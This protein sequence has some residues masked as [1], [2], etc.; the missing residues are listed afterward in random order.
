MPANYDEPLHVDYKVVNRSADNVTK[1][2]QRRSRL[3]DPARTA[4]STDRV[5]ARVRSLRLDES[6]DTAQSHPRSPRSREGSGSGSGWATPSTI[7]AR[8]VSTGETSHTSPAPETRDTAH[9]AS[10]TAALKKGLPADQT[11]LE[12]S[13]SVRRRVPSDV[14]GNADLPMV[15]PTARSSSLL[16][17]QSVDEVQAS[18]DSRLTTSDTVYANGNIARLPLLLPERSIDSTTTVNDRRLRTISTDH[19]TSSSD[20]TYTLN[21]SSLPVPPRPSQRN[22]VAGGAV[23]AAA[24]A[25]LAKYANGKA[26]PQMVGVGSSNGH[27]ASGIVTAGSATPK[28]EEGSEEDG[29]A[30]DRG[31]RAATP[32]AGRKEQVSK[33]PSRRV[34]PPQSPMPNHAP[35]ARPSAA[36]SL[37]STPSSSPSLSTS[38]SFAA[39]SRGAHPSPSTSFGLGF[40]MD[41]SDKLGR[42]RRS[43]ITPSLTPSCE[44]G[45][46]AGAAGSEYEYSP[47]IADST[48]TFGGLED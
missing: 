2:R 18:T 47:S 4:T 24:S 39:R 16:N 12:R 32:P 8:S 36:S 22:L 44:S 43:S 35:P 29:Y 42:E 38:N 7:S 23:A 30:T 33:T 21:A 48:H 15:M 40:G 1:D 19:H 45:L 27:A 17:K 28:S 10:L 26:S 13:G 20:S 11:E 25:R 34:L 6:A 31:L 5:A 37:S 3:T 9:A 41:A 46:G 14:N